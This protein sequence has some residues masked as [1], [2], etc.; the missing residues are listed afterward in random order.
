MKKYS[1]EWKA[2]KKAWVQKHENG[3]ALHYLE[4][5]TERKGTLRDVYADAVNDLRN[6]E[7]RI[8]DT[9]SSAGID[10][11]REVGRPQHHSLPAGVITG[12]KSA[13]EGKR[14]RR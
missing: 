2:D 3:W 5:T 10:P 8:V 6:Y 1:V 4:G 11:P 13:R 9:V 14:G 7:L 12:I